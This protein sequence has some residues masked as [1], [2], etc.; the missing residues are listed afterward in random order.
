MI[1]YLRIKTGTGVCQLAKQSGIHRRTISKLEN[2]GGNPSLYT[3]EMLLETMGY[4]I[5][6]VPIR[7]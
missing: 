4:E 5:E 6:I 7:G 1:Q 2:C 3:F